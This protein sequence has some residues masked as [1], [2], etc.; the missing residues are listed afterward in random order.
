MAARQQRINEGRADVKSPTTR[1]EHPFDQ[2]AHLINAED[3]RGEFVPAIASD[4]DPR[5][6]IDPDLLDGRVIE[7][8]LQWPKTGDVRHQPAD[9]NLGI[10][11]CVD[12]AG[13]TAPFV[14]LHY[15]SGNALNSRR[16]GARIDPLIAHSIAHSLGE[17]V[18]KGQRCSGHLFLTPPNVRTSLDRC[19]LFAKWP[20][21]AAILWITGP[22]R[23]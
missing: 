14:V 16:I 10:V 20:E 15:L 11:E 5:G 22:S 17:R 4:E 7:V 9:E 19:A 8:L 21:S 1:A 23:W 2:L 18:G 12:G 13:E 3:R 6:F